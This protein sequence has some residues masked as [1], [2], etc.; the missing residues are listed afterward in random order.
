MGRINERIAC[1]VPRLPCRADRDDVAQATWLRLLEI[2]PRFEHRSALT[3]FAAGVTR[4]VA[5]ELFRRERAERQRNALWREDILRATMAE[6]PDHAADRQGIETR[7]GT[8]LC[9]LAV[10]DRWLLAARA[11]GTTYEACLDRYHAAFGDHI[12]SV[13]GL[14]T[15]VFHARRRLVRAVIDAG[16]LSTGAEPV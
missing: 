14:R 9:E 6:P 11:E 15:A 10:R 7:L 2:L 1:L 13:E 3:T 4:R 8:A 5:S 12:R 16:G